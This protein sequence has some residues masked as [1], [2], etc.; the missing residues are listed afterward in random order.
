MAPRGDGLATKGREAALGFPPSLAADRKGP[1]PS[2]LLPPSADTARAAES[3]RRMWRGLTPGPE[4][5]NRRAQPDYGAASAAG[6]L[7]IH[8]AA[9]N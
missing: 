9:T 1:T 5:V 3:D 7:F 8:S 4:A 6:H 2:H